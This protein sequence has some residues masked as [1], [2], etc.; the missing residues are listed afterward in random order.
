M[1]EAERRGVTIDICPSCSGIWLDAGEIEEILQCYSAS[2]L[3]SWRPYRPNT[4]L[5]PTDPTEGASA[6]ELAGAAIVCLLDF[7]AGA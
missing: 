1:I 7:L 5:G 2:D 3:A 6:R 4:A